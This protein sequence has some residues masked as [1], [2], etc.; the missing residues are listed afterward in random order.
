[1]ETEGKRE[2]G[3]YPSGPTP[4]PFFVTQPS[5]WFPLPGPLAPAAGWPHWPRSLP[6]HRP[7]RF[8][9]I[10]FLLGVQAP[11]WPAPSPPVPTCALLPSHLGSPSSEDAPLLLLSP[12]GGTAN[13]IPGIVNLKGRLTCPPHYPPLPSD[14]ATS[15]SAVMVSL[16]I[17][18]GNGGRNP[19]WAPTI[20]APLSRPL[21]LP[22]RGDGMWSMLPAK[23]CSVIA[24][25]AH[26]EILLCSLPHRC[27]SKG[28]QTSSSSIWELV[29][30]FLGG[31]PWVA[32]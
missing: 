11:S 30:I 15:L 3:W 17:S 23:H 6:I 21:Y 25:E 1:M 14:Q 7:C 24:P 26:L 27:F 22:G 29:W 13:L 4:S 2:D 32:L 12:L 31:Y 20:S 8:F 16:P 5:L 9:L 10:P 28:A 18:L 19:W